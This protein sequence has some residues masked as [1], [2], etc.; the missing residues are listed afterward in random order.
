VPHAARLTRL[1]MALHG[2]SYHYHFVTWVAATPMPVVRAHLLAGRSFEM[3]VA[4]KEGV[5]GDEP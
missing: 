5:E 2:G 1:E 4:V 3:T